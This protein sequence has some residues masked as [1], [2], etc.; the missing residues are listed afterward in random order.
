VARSP[1]DGQLVV[2]RLERAELSRATPQVILRPDSNGP[3]ISA[4]LFDAVPLQLPKSLPPH[5]SPSRAVAESG[6][7][8]H[9]FDPEELALLAELLVVLAKKEQI[10]ERLRQTV[11]RMQYALLIVALEQVN[12]HLNPLLGKL[13]HHPHLRAHSALLCPPAGD[14]YLEPYKSIASGIQLSLDTASSALV[15]NALVL[16]SVVADVAR[17][18]VASTYNVEGQRQVLTAALAALA[19]RHTANLP[20]YHTLIQR[21]RLFLPPHIVDNIS[22]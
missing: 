14:P 17:Q 16:V 2:G 1:A 13:R 21:L 11:D 18:N 12:A 8:A 7:H 6:P 10:L 19:P 5:R 22:E 3:A 20:F 15:T 4:S 9:P